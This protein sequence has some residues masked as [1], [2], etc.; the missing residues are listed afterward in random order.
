LW[1]LESVLGV[2]TK[3]GSRAWE[4]RRKRKRTYNA[5]HERVDAGDVGLT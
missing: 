1:A 3:S 4:V 5:A 2:P